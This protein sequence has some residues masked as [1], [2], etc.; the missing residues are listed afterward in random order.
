MLEIINTENDGTIFNI[1]Q[2]ISFIVPYE[3][4]DTDTELYCAAPTRLKDATVNHLSIWTKCKV[5]TPVCNGNNKERDS[6]TYF[7]QS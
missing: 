6:L 3:S 7:R 4:S 1:K 2:K 5:A